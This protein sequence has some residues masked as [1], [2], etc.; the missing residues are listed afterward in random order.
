LTK[1]SILAAIL[2]AM[3]LVFSPALAEDQ[4]EL[5]VFT[6]ASLTG[7]FGEI[8]D[9]YQSGSGGK[10]IQNFDGSQMLRTQIENGA[11]ADV[12]ASA[13]KKHMYGLMAEGYMDNSSVITLLKNRMA[14]IVP[15]DNP[16][17][18]SDLQDLAEPG[19]KIVMGNSEVPVGSYARQVLDNLAAD[20]SFGEEYKTQVQ[21]NIISEETTVS[22]VV[23]KVALGEADAGFAY[24]SDVTPQMR[25]EINVIEIPE[26]YNIIAEYFIGVL[27]ESK[28]PEQAQSFIDFVMSDESS[29]V[30][31]KYGFTPIEYSG[32]ENAPEAATA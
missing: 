1:Q 30:L 21:D 7:A 32:S 26:E 20:P 9:L 6:A 11:Y 31:T 23:S 13:N 19:T 5:T 22:L 4:D 16:A 8:A 12:F 17:E 24:V 2:A 14:V 28:Y 10:V 15:K 27:L 3:M 25:S 18:I 29:D